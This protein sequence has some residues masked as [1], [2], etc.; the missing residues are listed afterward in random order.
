[1]V[2]ACIGK[3]QCRIVLGNHRA[4]L[5]DRMALALEE[6]EVRRANLGGRHVGSR[7]HMFFLRSRPHDRCGAR[8]DTAVQATYPKPDRSQTSCA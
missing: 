8:W 4:G 7:F 3:Q 6:L 1:M 2:H 5:D